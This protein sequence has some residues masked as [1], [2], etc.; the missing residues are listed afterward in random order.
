M[1]LMAN[2]KFQNPIHLMGERRMFS[3]SKNLR[4]FADA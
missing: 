4:D 3:K 2:F 1:Q